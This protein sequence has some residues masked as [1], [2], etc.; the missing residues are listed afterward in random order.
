MP[1]IVTFS[2][3][4]ILDQPGQPLRSSG[5]PN[6]YKDIFD[7]DV[8]AGS[9]PVVAGVSGETGEG[10]YIMNTTEGAPAPY[11]GDYVLPLANGGTGTALGNGTTGQYVISNGNGTL[12]YQTGVPGEGNVLG[13][14]SSVNGHIV[15]FAGTSGI[16]IQDSGIAIADFVTGPETSV[17]DNI[18]VFS[19]THGDT[20][21]DS[22]KSLSQYCLIPEGAANGDLFVWNEGVFQRIPA[23]TGFTS[24][25]F[26]T[27]ATVGDLPTWQPM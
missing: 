27:V 16:N 24:P 6:P 20:L 11:F 19:G 18:P 1:S 7:V 3:V 4:Y 8:P 22:G 2:P 14:D 17:V 10:L 5:L 25:V 21:S 26:L 15:T 12:S 13:P 9:F 23:P